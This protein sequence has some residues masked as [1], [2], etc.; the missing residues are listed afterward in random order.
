MVDEQLSHEQV[1]ERE[2]LRDAL[3]QTQESTAVQL[4]LEICLPE[5]DDVRAF[6][7]NPPLL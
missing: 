7:W 3:I 2:Q 6:P 4:L 1:I 5:N